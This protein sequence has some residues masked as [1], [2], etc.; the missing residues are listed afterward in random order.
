MLIESPNMHAVY[1]T[2]R[3]ASEVVDGFQDLPRQFGRVWSNKK[4]QSPASQ[5][6]LR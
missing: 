5:T 2:W 3:A 4:I 6:K 1:Q